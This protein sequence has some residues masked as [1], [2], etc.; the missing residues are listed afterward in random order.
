MSPFLHKETGPHGHGVRIP[1]LPRRAASGARAQSEPGTTREMSFC[2]LP[3]NQAPL[4]AMVSVGK[5][6]LSSKVIS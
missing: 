1:G 3:R 5:W 4:L 6:D 2:S